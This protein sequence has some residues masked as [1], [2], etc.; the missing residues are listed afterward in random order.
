M[1]QKFIEPKRLNDACRIHQ[2]NLTVA[3]DEL[4]QELEADSAGRPAIHRRHG[5][6]FD[7]LSTLGDHPHGCRTLGTNAAAVAD[8]LDIAADVDQSQVIAERRTDQIA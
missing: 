3:R 2:M 6:F 7:M 4:R 5:E 8:V 1:G